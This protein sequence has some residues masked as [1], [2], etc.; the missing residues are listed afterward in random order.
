MFKV[1]VLHGNDGVYSSFL[2]GALAETHPIFSEDPNALQ[3]VLYYDDI[4]FTT[5]SAKRIK[6]GMFYFTLGN[7]NATFRSI[8]DTIFLLAIAQYEDIRSYG[9]DRVLAPLCEELKQL[10]Q[11]AGFAFSLDQFYLPLRGAVVAVAADTP[12]SNYL[13]GF[14]EGVGGALRKCRHCNRLRNNAEPLR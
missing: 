9:V 4:S 6:L 14:K 13:S 3:I 12:A 8:V 5:T 1:K 10:S 2:D 7:F 11:P